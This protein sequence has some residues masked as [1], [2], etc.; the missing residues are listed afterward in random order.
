[1]TRDEQWMWCA[2]A[3]A[4]RAAGRGDRPFGCV[5]VYSNGDVAPH[6]VGHGGGSE[7][8]ND[9]TQ[10]CE[11]WAIR[12][13]YETLGKPLYGCTL[14]STHE[15]CIMCCGA[16]NHAKIGRVVWGSDRVDLPHMFR[17]RD[18]SARSLLKDT[19]TPSLTAS[20]VLREEC[21]LLLMGELDRAVR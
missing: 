10:H 19:S 6:V 11:M 21:R 20:G 18:V 3:V 12:E 1:M 5:I 15:P 13:A 4:E 8:G 17:Q 14:Y 9:P 2:I 16:I 7:F